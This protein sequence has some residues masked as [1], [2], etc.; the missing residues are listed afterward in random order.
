[1]EQMILNVYTCT[2]FQRV[3]QDH[4][5]TIH[6]NGS[7][8]KV[9]RF[10]SHLH[11]Y[12]CMYINIKRCM[13]INIKRLKS[14]ENCFWRF[15]QRREL[16]LL[17]LFVRSRNSSKKCFKK[18]RA[19]HTSGKRVY[20][21]IQG[22]IRTQKQITLIEIRR[23]RAQKQIT[24]IKIRRF[25]TQKQITLIDIN[26]FRTQKQITLIKNSSRHSTCL[27][28]ICMHKCA[29]SLSHIFFE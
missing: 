26:I 23:F 2:Y 7:C 6:M 18:Q 9:L 19:H 3:P 15:R 25:R 5:H 22:C 1:M 12:V 13:Y 4:V 27:L 8:P 28:H 20:Q 29:H 11:V 17:A 21:K 14:N 10:Y 24:L 16:S